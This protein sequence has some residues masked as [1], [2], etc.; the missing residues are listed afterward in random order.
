MKNRSALFVGLFLAVAGLNAQA[1]DLRVKGSIAPASC[2]FTITNSTLD[3]GRINP[4]SLSATNY[5]KL[6]KKGTPF[7]V[8]CSSPTMVGIK[9]LDNR[10]SS[11]VPGLMQVMYNR[12]YHDGFN[13]G[14]GTTAKGENIGGY[15]V[16]MENNVADGRAVLLARSFNNGATWHYTDQVLGQPPELGSWRSGSAYTPIR[17]KV[18]SGNL[19]V[20]PVIN[21]TSALTMN[22]EIMLDGHATLEL[23]YL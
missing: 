22:S 14:L 1:A 2:S 16:F 17:L 5:T 11:K 12:T 3:F 13:Y 19:R 10:A 18:V 15:V 8:S 9:T 4:S 21:K 23:V 20:Q 6:D 7:A